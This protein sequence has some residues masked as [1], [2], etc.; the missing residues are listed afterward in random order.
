MSEVK[1]PLSLRIKN[2]A[3]G[4]VS[5]FSKPKYIL[6]ALATS[7]FI[8]GF[9][10]WSLNFDLVKFILFEAPISFGEKIRF[11][12]DVQYGVWQAAFPALQPDDV[13]VSGVYTSFQA[14]GILIFS[15]LFGI[16]IAMITAMFKNGG[17]KS[18]P[19]KSGGGGL[20]LALLSGGCVACGTSILAP[21]LATFGA[22]SSVF[23]T[24]L[25]NFFNWAGSILILY[26]IYKLGGV[27]NNAKNLQ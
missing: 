25:A 16:N 27:I 4:F 11:F 23:L 13:I 8:S 17:L 2:S 12:W 19:K 14:L 10:I 18:I 26:S 1:A 20:I 3:R 21:I 6:L 5:V 24:D 7:V 9:I 22:T 15:G